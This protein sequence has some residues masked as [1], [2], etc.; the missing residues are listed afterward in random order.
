MKQ[1]IKPRNFVFHDLMDS[2]YDMKVVPN[3][4]KK[5]KFDS[6]KK[7]KKELYDDWNIT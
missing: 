1:K 2:K 6:Y 7:T 3:K 5:L 4:K